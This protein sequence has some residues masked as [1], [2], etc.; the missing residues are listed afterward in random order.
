[1]KGMG[2]YEDTNIFWEIKF[3]IIGGLIW[4]RARPY[5]SGPPEFVCE[6]LLIYEDMRSYLSIYL[7]IIEAP[8]HI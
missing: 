5:F 8:D 7:S 2:R 6:I 1:M 4:E 3:Y